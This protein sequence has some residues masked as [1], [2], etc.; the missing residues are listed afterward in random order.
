MTH[1]GE[2]HGLRARHSAHLERW[3]GTRQQQICM[4]RSWIHGASW[5]DEL[6]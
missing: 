3:I 2:G 6:T 4:V 1:G 5:T